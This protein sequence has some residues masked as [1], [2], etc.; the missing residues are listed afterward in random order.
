MKKIYIILTHTGTA[1]STIIKY[2]TKDA[3][4]HVSIALDENLYKMYSFGR[5]NPYNP[6]WGGFVH[7]EI[8]SGTFKRFKNTIAEVYSLTVDDKE[9]EKVSKVIKYFDENKE[10]YKFNTLGLLCV[11]IK[12]QIKYK[13]TFYCAE[14]VRHVLNVSGIQESS[15]PKIIKPEDFKMMTNIKLEYRGLLSKYNNRNKPKYRIEKKNINEVC[16]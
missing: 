9:Y 5:L 13:N 6:F 12:K 4:S 7:E 15:L 10:K 3:F 2:Y 11:C 14:F 1:L 8:T 16:V